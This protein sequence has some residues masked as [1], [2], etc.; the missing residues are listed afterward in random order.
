VSL[1]FA[2]VFNAPFAEVQIM[3]AVITAYVLGLVPFCLLFVVQRSFYALA[4]TRTPFA[5]TMAQVVLVIAGVLLSALLPAQWIGVGIAAAVSVA[6]T[7]QLLLASWLLARRIGRG[8]ARGVGRSLLIDLAA[9]VPAGVVGGALLV[10][11]GGTVEGGFALSG[12]LPAILSL[13]VISAAMTAVYGGALVLF[14]SPDLM[15]VLARIIARLK[16]R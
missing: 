12:K 10:L 8:S 6:G 3:A 4:D 2:R 9:V 14:R 16:R 7:I 13:A 5:F 11:L 1:P 15:P